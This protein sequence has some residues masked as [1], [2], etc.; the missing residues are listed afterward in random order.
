MLDQLFS[1]CILQ[2]S[3]ST[4]S[5]HC[6]LLLGLHEFTHGKCCFHFESLTSAG[7]FRGG[8]GTV[9]GAAGGGFLPAASLGDKLKRLSC[10]L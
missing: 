4:T 7:W 1:D 2:S 8:G 9:M 3:A 5:D 10:H 6:P